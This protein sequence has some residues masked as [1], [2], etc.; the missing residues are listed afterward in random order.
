MDIFFH[1][2]G[3]QPERNVPT[4]AIPGQFESAGPCNGPSAPDPPECMQPGVR[5]WEPGH[6]DALPA[7]PAPSS[8]GQQ[9]ACSPHLAPGKLTLPWMRATCALPKKPTEPPRC[10]HVRAQNQGPAQPQGYK[11]GDTPPQASLVF[12]TRTAGCSFLLPQTHRVQA[13]PRPRPT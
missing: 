5:G 6:W 2:Q 4:P 11:A 12:S 3:E 10:H 8:S 13:S 7:R 9:P 1:F